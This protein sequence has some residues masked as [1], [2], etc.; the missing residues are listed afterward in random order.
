MKRAIFIII[1]FSVA[2]LTSPILNA[3]KYASISVKRGNVRTCPSMDCKIKFYMWK[4]TPVE[5][6]SVSDDKNW[7]EVKDFE[8][9]RGWVHKTLL[10]ETPAMS[11]KEDVNVRSCAGDNCEKNW[12][13]K[14]GYSF[15]F[16]ERKGNWY[17]VTD[18]DKTTGWVY[19]RN[20]WGFTKYIK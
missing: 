10:D 9:Y 18:D 11:A 14:K 8:G 4:Y 19:N 15:K 7:V 12:I 3:A 17:K 20:L 13:V 5:M 1:L 16:L 2:F 6:I